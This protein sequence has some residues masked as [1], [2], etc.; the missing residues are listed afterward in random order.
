MRGREPRQ[1]R[2]IEVIVVRVRHQH[3]VDW[4][5]IRKGDSR[6]V[7]PR[8]PDHPERRCAPRPDRVEQQ[9]EPAV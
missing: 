9:V 8:R 7:H 1:G 4:R 2:E 6:I 5:Q 3:G